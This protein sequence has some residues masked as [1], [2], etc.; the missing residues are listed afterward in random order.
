MKKESY[1]SFV[2]QSFT[3]VFELTS[4][5]RDILFLRSRFEQIKQDHLLLQNKKKIRY[6]VHTNQ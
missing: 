6:F 1:M 5:E 3:K 2:H 4:N